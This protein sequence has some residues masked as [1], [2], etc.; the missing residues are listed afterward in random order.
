MTITQMV[1]TALV[2][3]FEFTIAEGFEVIPR[4]VV[5]CQPKG[6]LPLALRER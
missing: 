5:T 3:N 1:V 2:R 4:Y 6:G